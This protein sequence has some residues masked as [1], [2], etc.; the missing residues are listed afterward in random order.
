VV[1]SPH[2]PDPH[3]AFRKGNVLKRLLLVALAGALIGGLFFLFPTSEQK[4]A[5]AAPKRDPRAQA[6]IG[7]SVSPDIIPDPRDQPLE[8]QRKTSSTSAAPHEPQAHSTAR[9]ADSDGFAHSFKSS[10]K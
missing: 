7:R 6:V 9:T 1:E 3:A 2:I 10:A 5:I 8:E 4:S